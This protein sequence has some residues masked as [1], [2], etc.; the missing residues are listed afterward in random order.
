MATESAASLRSTAERL[1][2]RLKTRI[3]GLEDTIELLAI[4]VLA[5]QHALLEGVPGLAKT[6]LVQSLAELMDLRFARIQFTPDLMPADITGTEVIAEDAGT[7]LREFRFLKGP[8]FA[9]L[10]LADEIN[11]TPPKTQAALMEAMEERQVTARGERT[12]LEEPFSVLATRNPIE[13]EG[14]YPLP[15]AQ[16]DRFL[17]LL[18]LDYPARADELKILRRT[19]A[20]SH[21]ALGPVLTREELLAAIRE[22]RSTPLPE[23]VARTI[24]EFVRKTR[25]ADAKAPELVRQHVELGAGPRAGQMLSLA[26][27]AR[28]RLHGRA[29]PD[30][31]DLRALAHPVLRHRLI[32]KHSAVAEDINADAII[33]TLLATLPAPRGV[34]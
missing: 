8:L 23:T 18:K 28:A 20:G 5:G 7:G 17:F 33:N 11:R 22:V 3:V 2:G 24:A 25:P 15:A 19:T 21:A 4:T 6:L 32:L 1:T 9:N 29:Q 16:L 12:P 34:R 14:T 30:V 13:Q 26:M 31:N 27:V 10:V